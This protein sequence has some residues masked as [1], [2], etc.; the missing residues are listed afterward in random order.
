MRNQKHILLTGAAG[1]IGSHLAD[2]LLAEGHIVYG[3]DNLSYGKISNLKSSI[4]N[5][6]FNFTKINVEDLFINNFPKLDFIFHLASYKKTFKGVGLDASSVMLNNSKMLHK[7]LSLSEQSNAFLIFSSTSDVYGSSA[8]FKEKDSITIGP[9]TNSR[10]SY[11]LSKLYEEQCILNYIDE[12][13]INGC[14]FRIFGCS[15]P[16][17]SKS[18]SGGHVPLFIIN[19][20]NNID[21]DI[22]GDGLQTRSICHAGDIALGLSLSVLNKKSCNGEIINLGTDEQTTVKEVAEYIINKTKSTSK[23]NYIPREEVFGDYKEI[24]IRFANTEKAKE[25]LNFK[26]SK[27]TFSV[28]DDIISTDEDSSHNTC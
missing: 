6:N 14:V 10:Y 28:I 1:C 27:S 11:A 3:I 8:T 17:A 23:I 9:P 12:G 5:K 2:V 24:M 25:I 19:A 16:R 15:S 4:N 7:V 21:I 18:W 26:I 20:L 22:H 13:K